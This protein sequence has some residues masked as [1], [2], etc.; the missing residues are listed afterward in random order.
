MMEIG[1]RALPIVTMLSATIGVMLALQGIYSLKTF[2]AESQVTLGVALGVTRE[3]A[4]LITGILVAGRSGSA[5]AARLGTMIISNEVDALRVMGVNPVRYLVVPGLLAMLVMLPALALWADFVALSAA[6]LYITADLG[7]TLGAYVQETLRAIS[8]DDLTHGLTKSLL[9]A[10]LI[11]IVAV[12]DGSSVKG[13]AE[14]VGRVTTQSV[15]HSI[16]AIVLTDMLFV[17]AAT[18]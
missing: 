2:G 18:R 15:V 10:A 4:P 5:L 3:F 14:G 17:F 16:M 11:T 7:M 1:I 12:V 8:I 13:G 9:F 6:G